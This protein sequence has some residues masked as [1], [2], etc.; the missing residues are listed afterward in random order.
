MLRGIPAPLPDEDTQ[1]FWDGCADGRL[2]VPECAACGA[3]RWPPGP[4]C[5]VCQSTETHWLEASRRGTLYSWIVAVH[6][7]D[8]VLAD[9]VPYTVALVELDEGVRVIGNVLDVD[10]AELVAGM[11]LDVVF[12][13]ADGIRLPNFRR[14]V[15]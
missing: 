15:D 8:Q 4:M 9:Q 7:T 3:R 2:L 13:E 11:P 6:P 12:E 1:P 5:P 14:T 10:P